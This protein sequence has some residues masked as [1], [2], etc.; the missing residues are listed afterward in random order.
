MATTLNLP[1]VGAAA[2][3]H[4]HLPVRRT[5]VARQDRLEV[6]RPC[7]LTGHEA[8]PTDFPAVCSSVAPAAQ[9]GREV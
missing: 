1:H 6:R 4:G 8:V 7:V 2:E 5:A 9:A 3:R